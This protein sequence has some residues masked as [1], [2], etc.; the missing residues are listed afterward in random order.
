MLDGIKV[1]GV[2]SQFET[3]LVL[4]GDKAMTAFQLH[5]YQLESSDDW[6]IANGPA[7]I[8]FKGPHPEFLLFLTKESNNTYK[9]VSGQT[10]PAGVSVLE[11][12]T[13]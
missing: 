2:L 1:V 13:Y 10:D 8:T 11:L 5:H 12:T 4:K 9:P 7:L 3:K 6:R